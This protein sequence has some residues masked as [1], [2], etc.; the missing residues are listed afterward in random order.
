M[1]EVPNMIKL[2]R[3]AFLGA[4]A[5][6]AGTLA[7]DLLWYRR[8]R[9]GGGSQDFFAWETSEGLK[10][11]EDAPAPARTAKVVAGMADIDLPDSS[12]RAA[13]NVVHWMT[14]VSWGE[15]HGVAAAVLGTSN[16]GLGLGTAVVA[17][18]TS[19]GVLPKLGVYKPI[20]EYDGDALWQD[21]SAHLV[22]GAALGLVFRLISPR[23]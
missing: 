3:S 23:S 9:A 8:F 12:A 18:V 4:V 7:M 14:G 13:N 20:S 5:G 19:Y 16:P 2:I 15:A 11:Y 10:G 17:W 22:F 6:A 1:V 21:L